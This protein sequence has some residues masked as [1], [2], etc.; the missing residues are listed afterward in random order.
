MSKLISLREKFNKLYIKTLELV[1]GDEV[2]I[3]T[4]L[5]ETEHLLIMEQLENNKYRVITDGSLDNVIKT[6]DLN[7]YFLN[8]RLYK[9]PIDNKNLHRFMRDA[10]DMF[11]PM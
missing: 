8:N 11:D 6:E 2:L 3:W 10:H 7:N 5:D 4:N 1:P 9:I